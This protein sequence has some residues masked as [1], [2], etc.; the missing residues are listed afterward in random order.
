MKRVFVD[1]SAI[2]AL[3]IRTDA[4]HEIARSVLASLRSKESSLVT[5]SFAVQE[6]I[7]LLQHR[8]GIDAVRTVWG[9]LI[10]GM[11]VVYVDQDMLSQ[12]VHALLA[13]SR[14]Q[15]SLTDWVGITIMRQQGIQTAFAFDKHFSE[16]G[17]A[18]P[19]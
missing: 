2:Y 7:A 9:K 18:F 15:V 3:T 6:S 10:S 1:T 4:N 14:R 8:F 5:S 16:Q 17:F 13:A 12:S 19:E 11:E